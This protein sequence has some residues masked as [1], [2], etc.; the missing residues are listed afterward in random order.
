[1]APKLENEPVDY[2]EYQFREV[3]VMEED[4]MR[5]NSASLAPEMLKTE[6]SE[7]RDLH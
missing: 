4:R 7:T 5:N 2:S 3:W 1:M 6:R